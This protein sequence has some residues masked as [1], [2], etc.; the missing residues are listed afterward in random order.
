M[1]VKLIFDD[2]KKGFESI[3]GTERGIDLEMGSFHGGTTFNAE[4]E[5]NKW[6]EKDFEEALKEGITPYFYMDKDTLRK[7]KQIRVFINNCKIYNVS[8]FYKMKKVLIKVLKDHVSLEHFSPCYNYDCDVD[9]ELEDI[10]KLPKSLQKEALS[11]L[12]IKKEI[13]EAPAKME[14]Y[15]NDI[16]N[17]IVNAK[18]E[19]E[20]F[21]ISVELNEKWRIGNL[22]SDCKFIEP[23]CRFKDL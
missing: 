23:D 2:W 15:M 17:K 16:I 22:E 7:E 21:K 6:E 12:T 3:H 13:L 11:M 14:N 19:E 9:F 5:L 1:K 8:E 18:S 20:L 10:P 4:I